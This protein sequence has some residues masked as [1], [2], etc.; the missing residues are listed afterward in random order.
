[1]LIAAQ[2][3]FVVITQAWF[4]RGDLGLPPR[5]AS[6]SRLRL[7][8]RQHPPSHNA[9]AYWLVCLADHLDVDMP[10]VN[11]LTITAETFLEHCCCHVKVEKGILHSA[12]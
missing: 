4:R 1:M 8:R 3:F 10:K 12:C 9:R 6:S 5:A 7:S 2:Q 11:V